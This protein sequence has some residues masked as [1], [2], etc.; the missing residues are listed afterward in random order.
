MSRSLHVARE[1]ELEPQYGLPERLP[2]GERIL[3][4]GNP[5]WQR[6]AR[7]A[8]HADKLAIY[9]AVLTVWRVASML[10]DGA[11]GAEVLR[12]LAW[13]LPLFALALGLVLLLAWL[14]A[15]T[16]VYTLTNLRVVMRIGIVL[17]VAF[18][19]P[20]RRIEGAALHRAGGQVGDIALTLEAD[21]RIAWLQLWP[22]VRPWK[23]ARAQPMLRALA[24]APRVAQ[25]LAEAWGA[26]HGQR[27]AAVPASAP[28]T[29]AGERPLVGPMT[30]PLAG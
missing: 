26:V 7:S 12:S 22:H 1:H 21:T 5:Q 13:L 3:W 16:T 17:T 15:R 28:H 27:V 30:H 19:L 11:T 14:T 6:L 25:Q 29:P 10:G 4:Q 9:F 18:N 20:L 2:Q 24:D 8:F 23:V